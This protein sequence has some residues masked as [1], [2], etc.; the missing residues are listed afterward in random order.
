LSDKDHLLKFVS[1]LQHDITDCG[2]ACLAIVCKQY[3]YKKPI[4]QI[5]EVAGTD[6]EGTNAFGLLK[7]AKELGLRGKRISLELD[8][9]HTS[10]CDNKSL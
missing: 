7:A 9:R 5:R 8:L 3:G 6:K 1:N 4:S 2:A 10:A